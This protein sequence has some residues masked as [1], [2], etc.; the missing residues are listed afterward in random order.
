MDRPPADPA[1]L[2]SAWSEW[3]TDEVT[4]GRAVANLKTGG[5]RDVVEHLAGDPDASAPDGCDVTTMLA[6]WMEWEVGSL[7][8]L[9]LVEGLRDAGMRPLLESLV[10]AAGAATSAGG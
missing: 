5:L 3:E 8:P 9:P 1:K 4:P 2:L 7:P 10:Q 6:S